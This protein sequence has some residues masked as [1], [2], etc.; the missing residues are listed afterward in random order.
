LV[1]LTTWLTVLAGPVP[2]LNPIILALPWAAATY[3]ELGLKCSTM[4]V[5]FSIADVDPTFSSPA[6]Q[7]DVVCTSI[8]VVL[9]NTPTM[10][11]YVPGVN[12]T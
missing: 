6:L 8:L 9:K 12:V 3:W 1:V 7:L 4:H 2:N 11:L 5:T 10:M